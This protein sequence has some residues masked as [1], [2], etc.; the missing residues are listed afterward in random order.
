MLLTPKEVAAQ[1]RLEPET[2]R[3]YIRA[4]TLRAKKLP[5]GW[6]VE[7]EEVRAFLDRLGSTTGRTPRALAIEAHVITARENIRR[8]RQ[9]P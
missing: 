3:R 5:G 2:I 9:L 8:M 4:G 6:R 1:L 7:E